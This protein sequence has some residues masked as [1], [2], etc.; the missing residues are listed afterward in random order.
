MT[1]H[2]AWLVVEWVSSKLGM[3]C[4]GGAQIDGWLHSER[5]GW[6]L[7]ADETVEPSICLEGI[8]FEWVDANDLCI[9]VSELDVA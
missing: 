8:G 6:N 5:L 4:D 7:P 2:D 3:L 9:S 1:L